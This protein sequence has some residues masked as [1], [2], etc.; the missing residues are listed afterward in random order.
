MK[1]VIETIPHN[2]QRYDTVGDYWTDPDG[3][4]QLRVSD[5]KSFNFEMLLALHELVELTL[6]R[7]HGVTQEDIDGFDLPWVPHDDVKEPGDDLMAPYWS[8]HQTA[9][10]I[11]RTVAAALGVNW[12]EYERCIDLLSGEDD[13]NKN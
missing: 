3:T 10:G 8:E 13:G 7:Q 6:C 9:T 11:E 12:L 5:L 4:I 2:C 1:V